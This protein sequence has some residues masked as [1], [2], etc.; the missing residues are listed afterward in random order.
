MIALSDILKA[1]ELW[2]KW[3]AISGLPDRVT[4]LEARLKALES[5]A[6]A[7]QGP[8]PDDCPKCGARMRLD[9]EEDDRHFGFAGV[10]VHYLV[11][12]AC[13]SNATRQWK[14]ETGYG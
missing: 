6:K 1:L 8:A 7:R 4:Q 14:P 10:K 12:D 11:C 2:P 13:G 9:R 3:K 5:G